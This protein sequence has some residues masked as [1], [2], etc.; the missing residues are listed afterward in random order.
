[1]IV[2]PGRFSLSRYIISFASSLS[3]PLVTTCQHIAYAMKRFDNLQQDSTFFRFTTAMFA[4][5]LITSATI[6]PLLA[7][8]SHATPVAQAVPVPQ[9]L[10]P[11]PTISGIYPEPQR[12]FGICSSIHDPNI[13][14]EDGTY[15]RF[16]T[17]NNISIATS[18]FLEGP[19]TFRGALLH[20][21]SSIHLRDD[22]DIW[23]RRAIS[24]IFPTAI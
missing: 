10:S 23:V 18:P 22:Q 21:G 6:F 24:H 20:N 14:Y 8:F 11:P 7:Q 13:V 19:W 3:R 17:S 12:C 15:W 1:M 2:T 4:S 9:G 16:T 5:L